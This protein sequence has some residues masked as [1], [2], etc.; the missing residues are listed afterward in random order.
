MSQGAGRAFPLRPLALKLPPLALQPFSHSAIH[1]TLRR[2][3]P[4]A[5]LQSSPSLAPAHLPATA[6]SSSPGRR[7]PKSAA[8]MAC[9]PDTNWMRTAAASAP[10]TSATTCTQERQ[11]GDSSHILPL[12]TFLETPSRSLAKLLYC[13]SA[14]VQTAAAA[15]C[16]APTL[17]VCITCGLLASWSWGWVD[18]GGAAPVLPTVP[19]PSGNTT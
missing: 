17:V 13:C 12:K 9:V 15:T 16:A 2:S 11:G 4:L 5:S 7:Q 18:L 14:S 1:P 10:I 19:C 3:L 6:K 8:E